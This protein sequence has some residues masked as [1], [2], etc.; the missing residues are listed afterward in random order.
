MIGGVN[1]R[2]LL[3]STG[4]SHNSHHRPVILSS[5]GN[6]GERVS[7]VVRADGSVFTVT[8]PRHGMDSPTLRSG[9]EDPWISNDTGRSELSAAG[10][11][12]LAAA[13]EMA[14]CLP[15]AG[16]RRPRL[17]SNCP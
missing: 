7:T 8:V 6:R 1:D 14:G 10:F 13:A 2:M 17:A 5:L 3:S 11:F 12:R 15:R 9:P 4:P 16:G